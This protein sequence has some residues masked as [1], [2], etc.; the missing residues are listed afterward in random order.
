MANA[1]GT[2]DRPGEGWD[3]PF[4]KFVAC[5]CDRVR[6]LGMYEAAHVNCGANHN[7][8]KYSDHGSIFVLQDEL[9]ARSRRGLDIWRSCPYMRETFGT[10]KSLELDCNIGWDC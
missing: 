10:F 5:D 4:D 1:S 9:S 7:S 6:D 2:V 8:P 3:S